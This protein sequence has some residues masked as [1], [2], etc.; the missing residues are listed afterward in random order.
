MK[1]TAII[2]VPFLI[3][4]ITLGASAQRGPGPSAGPAGLPGPG[5]PNRSEALAEYLGLS[6]AQ[7]AAWETLQSELRS[8]SQTLHEQERTVSEQLHNSLES[9]ST[10][11][12]ALGAL[13]IQLRTIHTQLEAAKDAADAKFEASL[14][15]DQ[16]AKYA[17][18]QV[19]SE[20]LQQ[21]G[22]GG[23]H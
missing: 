3:L 4:A 6:A 23:P 16:K 1:R 21:R 11:A 20:F 8:T 17:A 5:G 19:A 18:F 9:G 7:K 13:L 12:A 22:P 15:A 10:D 14:S 2:A